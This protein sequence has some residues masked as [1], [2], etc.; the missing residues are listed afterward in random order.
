MVDELRSRQ[1]GRILPEG[2][3]LPI[4]FEDVFADFASTLKEVWR[5]NAQVSNP[6]MR[7]WRMET[8][9]MQVCSSAS[10]PCSSAS[11]ASNSDSAAE[12]SGIGRTRRL[13]VVA[14]GGSETVVVVVVVLVRSTRSN[15]TMKT[16][17][18]R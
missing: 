1:H 6:R 7:S 2:E 13:L 18:G 11:N 8:D 4:A 17:N 3:T 12:P 14:I 9:S 16:P 10:S 15:K 5:P